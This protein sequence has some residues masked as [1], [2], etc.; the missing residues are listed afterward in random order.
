MTYT[1]IKFDIT[2][3][4]ETTSY[5]TLLESVKKELRK[6][7][8]NCDSDD[9]VDEIDDDISNSDEEILKEIDEIENDEKEE[10]KIYNSCESDYDDEEVELD[11]IK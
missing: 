3:D 4:N 5:Y 1:H 2:F 10:C 9:D 11:L 8:F 6:A 7:Y